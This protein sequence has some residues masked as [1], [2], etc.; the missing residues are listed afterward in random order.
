MRTQSNG[1]AKSVTYGFL[2]LFLIYSLFP[3]GWMLSTSLKPEEQAREYPPRFIPQT[4][5]LENYARV[6]TGTSMPR[7]LAN[8]LIL[9][10]GTIVGVLAL[11]SLGGYGFSRFRFPGKQF[12]F[13]A[14]LASVMISGIS[15]IVPLYVMFLRLGLLNTHWPL[16]CI[17]VT[18][19]LPI[20]VWLLKAYFDSIPRELGESALI[21]GCSRLG[22]LWRVILPTSRPGLVAVALYTF[23]V[24]WREFI[25]AATFIGKDDLKTMPVGIY[26]FFTELG[27]EWGKLGAASMLVALPP[28]ILFFAF[29]RWFNPGAVTGALM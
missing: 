14:M 21:D 16:L 18:Q 28:A 4:V 13:L 26:M 2:V 12:L 23:V 10:A 11:A 1:T 19:A 24:V 3:L 5:T 22:L 8:S 29:Q 20:S 27:I 17:Y 15:I 7:F 6:L 9:S 25:I